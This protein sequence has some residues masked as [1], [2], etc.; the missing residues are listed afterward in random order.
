MNYKTPEWAK[1]PPSDLKYQ[2]LKEGSI[3]SESGLT[4]DHLVV[5]KLP[6]CDLV[7][8]HP[9]VSRQH[10]V[11]Q[12][13]IK[14]ESELE[15]D[16]CRAYIY[17]L[18]S[19]NGTFVNKSKI[20]SKEFVEIKAWDWIKFGESSRRF[21]LCGPRS[22][23]DSRSRIVPQI[24][25][26]IGNKHGLEE[27]VWGSDIYKLESVIDRK[28]IGHDH[29]YCQDP[30]RYLLAFCDKH[31]AILKFN[32]LA[33]NNKEYKCE[34]HIEGLKGPFASLGKGSSKVLAENDACLEACTKLDL[35]DILRDEH[36][37]LSTYL[38]EKLY[39]EQLDL[40]DEYYDR[41]KHTSTL[42]KLKIEQ[43]ETFESLNKKL[44]ENEQEIQRLERLLDHEC[45]N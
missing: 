12:F 32:T 25:S 30:R 26:V 34:L 3:I 36:G 41:T 33:V 14:N 37:N 8:E 45:N 9:S 42:K 19:S 10:A 35:M 38:R 44:E 31:D 4:K 1:I 13:G 11:I 22:L 17:D 43:V 6:S 5:G 27:N 16:E 20:P 40:E 23:S 29:D 39:Q 15:T 2:I 24:P 18:G 28:Q 21:M 7:L